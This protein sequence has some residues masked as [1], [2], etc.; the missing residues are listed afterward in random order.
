VREWRA[1]LSAQADIGPSDKIHIVDVSDPSKF[2]SLIQPNFSQIVE[3]IDHRHGYEDYWRDKMNVVVDLEQVGACATQIYERW[4]ASRQ[5]NSMSLTSKR[6]LVTAILDNTLNFKSHNTTLR[7]VKAYKTLI[8]AAKLPKEWPK[9]Y[10]L[11]CQAGIEANLQ[12]AVELDMKVIKLP[13]FGNL[14]L[15]QLV[16]WNAEKIIQLLPEIFD[17][18]AHHEP[19][20]YVMNVI[21]LSHNRS[22]IL[23]EASVVKSYLSRLLSIDFE[24]HT[25]KAPRLWLRKEIVAQ[26]HNK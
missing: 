22:L 10:F 6:L 9:Q 19:E 18:L 26:A 17:I 24:G 11:T 15:G 13:G 14:L 3:V 2:D 4:K 7:D 20:Q 12:Q 1:L 8:K 21:D 25:A 5:L 23:T 16:V